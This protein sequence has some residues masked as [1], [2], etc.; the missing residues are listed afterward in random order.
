MMQRYREAL[1]YVE[2]FSNSSIKKD[3]PKKDPGLFIRRTQFLLDEIGNPEKNLKYVHVT[4]T[5]GKGTTSVLIHAALVLDGRKAG[6]FST[7]YVTAAI[8]QIQVGEKYISP[9]D[10]AEIILY[11]KP[12]IEKMKGDPRYGALTAFEIFFVT[13]L[14]YFKK[15]KCEWAVIEVGVGGRFDPTNVIPNP[16]VTVITNID[17]DHT[18]ILG[19]TLREIAYDKA[20][21]IKKGSVF[22][23]TEKRASLIRLFARISRESNASF[24]QVKGSNEDLARTVSKSLGICSEIFDKAS[25][26]VKLPC[27][28]EIMQKNPFV[29][30][31][32]AHDRIKMSHTLAELKKLDYKKLILVIATSGITDDNKK[33][34]PV[35]IPAADHIIIT[36][37]TGGRRSLAH[38]DAIVPF[39]RMYKKA[40]AGV[41]VVAE[42]RAARSAARLLASSGD[43][44]LVTGSFFLAGELRKEWFSEEWILENRK[45]FE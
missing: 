15:Q 12:F 10:F 1:S 44:I 24:N 35:I 25:N 37:L 38:P 3:S 20:G 41:E 22:F 7:P 42:A 17:L 36:S 26:T 13:A 28:F 29:I 4:G 9:D 43:C 14:V 21:I 27:R 16:V 23:T 39:V 6:L 33:I 34:F 2:S 8:E 30:L 19:K 45:S 11:L 31:D 5:A 32:G 18:N 40:G